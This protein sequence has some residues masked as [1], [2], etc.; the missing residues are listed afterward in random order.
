MTDNQEY[1]LVPSNEVGYFTR[2][3]DGVSGMTVT[4]LADFCGVD[5][6]VVTNLLNKIRDSNPILNDLED[7]LKPYAGKDWRLIS[8]DPQG[9]LIIIDDV[10][11]SVVEYYAFDART[12]RGKDIARNNFRV[13]AKA[14]M[15]LFI[16]SKTGY[17]PA[18]FHQ[19]E[20]TKSARGAYWYK[21]LGL[22]M[23]SVDKPLQ[24]GYFCIYLEMMRFFSELETRLGYVVQDVN[25][26]T[27]EYIIPDISIGLKFNEFLRSEDELAYEVRKK[28]LGSGNPID[29]RDAA[30]LKSGYRPAGANFH[31][32]LYYKHVYPKESHGNDN[33]KDAKSYPNEYKSIFHYYL[34]EHYIPDRCLPYIEKRDPE[35]IKQ[36]RQTISLMPD[37][38][39]SA[40]S[41]TLVGRFIRG[42]LPPSKQ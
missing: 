18:E 42:L 36:V 35:G 4:S 11:Q 37:K 19:T 5:Q 41:G 25:L 34:E 23:S 33:E 31:E 3:P 22:A 9:R 2:E 1:W 30:N 40:L 10:C 15:R 14:G 16:W 12:Y 13:I 24:A 32:I 38:T 21:R 26:A 28:F 17:I 8:N 39:K 7:C 27:D 6:P 29:F 20:E